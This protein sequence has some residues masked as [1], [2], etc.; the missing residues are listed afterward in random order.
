MKYVLRV[1][2]LSFALVLSVLPAGR[3]TAILLGSSCCCSSPEA[4]E[5]GCPFCA[6]K[7]RR[8]QAL[9]LQCLLHPKPCC[10]VAPRDFSAVDS[11]YEGHSAEESA[12]ETG[13]IYFND[14]GVG[15]IALWTSQFETPPEAQTLAPPQR[16]FIAQ[17]RPQFLI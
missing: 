13:K 2:V 3:C 16:N 12:T 6:A 9:R 8:A 14:F 1:V 5:N 17:H 11:G 10:P 15:R 7:A 4:S